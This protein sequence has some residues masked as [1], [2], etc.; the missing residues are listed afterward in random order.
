[1]SGEIAPFPTVLE[2]PQDGLFQ[3][4]VRADIKTTSGYTGYAWKKQIKIKKNHDLG[5]SKTSVT[6]TAGLMSPGQQKT[7]PYSKIKQYAGPVDQG[8]PTQITAIG[9]KGSAAKNS[10][11]RQATRQ[12]HPTF[13]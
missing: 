7:F 6:A 12:F 8:S 10:P 9:S 11:K 5:A 13:T 4:P 2:K 1:M 3:Q